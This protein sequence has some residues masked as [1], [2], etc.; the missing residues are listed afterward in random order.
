MCMQARTHTHTRTHTQAHTHTHAQAHLGAVL[1]GEPG[2][3]AVAG[4]RNGAVQLLHADVEHGVPVGNVPLVLGHLNG[5]C[6]AEV[7]R[8]EGG[9]GGRRERERGRLKEAR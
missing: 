5:T 3:D 7:G 1:A 2:E 8:P 6:L 9:E 4:A